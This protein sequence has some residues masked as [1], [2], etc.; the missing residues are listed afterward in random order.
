[1]KRT[2][3][4]LGAGASKDVFDFFPTGYELVKEVAYHL[5]TDL[6]APAVEGEGPCISPLV[7]ELIR[8]FTHDQRLFKKAIPHLVL[9]ELPVK[10]FLYA[11]RGI[12]TRL[13]D[14][15]MDYEWHRPR[16]SLRP[17]QTVSLDAFVHEQFGSD[18]LAKSII[19]HCIAYL[20]IGC[21]Q[22]LKDRFGGQRLDEFPE[23]W[24]CALAKRLKGYNDDDLRQN[25]HVVTFNYDRSFEYLLDKQ[26]MQLPEECVDHFYGTLG[27]MDEL[28]FGSV[29]DG[30][31]AVRKTYE[32]FRLLY[33]ERGKKD[34]SMNEFAQVLLLG[35]GF[36][37][38]N[39]EKL[40]LEN[41]QSPVKL[42][43]GRGI[44]EPRRG[45]LKA[46]GFEFFF[47]T[48]VG[49]DCLELVESCSF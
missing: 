4:V 49:N 47:P 29:N 2:L 46:K 14:Y 42:A 26:G 48:K 7:N 45:E 41:L 18:P 15:V 34:W 38:L 27:R 8:A 3:L 25:L 35:F 21:E 6:R 32:R 28:P 24:V 12:R 10:D 37:N 33:P 17:N 22:A 36:D 31:Q 11:V 13:W 5:T 23:N 19:Q 1:M 43:T 44:E 16:K 39:V 40:G 30:T 9:N 20:L